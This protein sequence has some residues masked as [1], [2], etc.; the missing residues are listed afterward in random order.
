M[1]GGVLIGIVFIAFSAVLIAGG[2]LD[3]ST[4]PRGSQF[5][6]FCVAVCLPTL[7]LM[8]CF[9][10]I[11]R[12]GAARL[13]LKEAK[14]LD[15]QI[16]DLKRQDSEISEAELHQLRQQFGERSLDQ[17]KGMV[18]DWSALIDPLRKLLD[19]GKGWP[20]NFE[21]LVGWA[22]SSVWTAEAPAPG[23]RIRF[24]QVRQRFNPSW[25]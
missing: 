22:A 2:A 16:S 4:V 5:M 8:G 6:A 10:V 1:L 23:S 21:S 18:E 14:P 25:R 20:V 12:A 24:Q 9:V 7:C 11:K 17:L 19:Q 13:A 15:A 3:D